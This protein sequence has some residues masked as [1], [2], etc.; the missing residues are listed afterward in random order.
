MWIR[1]PVRSWSRSKAL[2]DSWTFQKELWAY[3]FDSRLELWILNLK[4]LNVRVQD[5]I[6]AC[7]CIWLWLD[8][9]LSSPW[10]DLRKLHKVWGL[11]YQV[12]EQNLDIFWGLE[13][14]ESLEGLAVRGWMDLLGGYGSEDEAASGIEQESELLDRSGINDY[15]H[16]AAVG[17]DN[18]SGRDGECFTL[19]MWIT[20]LVAGVPKKWYFLKG[21]K[22]R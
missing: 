7:I 6:E 19:L 10:S 18:F 17:H 15:S 5:T 20:L 16:S 8:F 21:W 2:F 9:N 13:S 3:R 11:F 12:Q 14:S 1:S 4:P 22:K